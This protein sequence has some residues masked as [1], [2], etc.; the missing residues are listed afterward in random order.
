MKKPVKQAKPKRKPRTV[1]I[2]AEDGRLILANGFTARSD[3]E[4]YSK[5]RCYGY[6]HL[7]RTVHKFVEVIE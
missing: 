5:K 7:P 2:V 4:R 6:E 3:A 1:Y